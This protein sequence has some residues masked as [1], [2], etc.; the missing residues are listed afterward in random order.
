MIKP[1]F[2]IVNQGGVPIVKV[3]SLDA[4]EV[5]Q[6]YRQ[7]DGEAYAFIRPAPS[8]SK[9]AKS[10]ARPAQDAADATAKPAAKR[11]I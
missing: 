9:S 10:T 6:A 1:S 4:D 8:K 7:T 3:A 5:L 11:K 2:L